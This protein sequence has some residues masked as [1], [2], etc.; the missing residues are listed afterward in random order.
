MGRKG[1]TKKV[2]T[3]GA[4]YQGGGVSLGDLLRARG[5]VP[6]APAPAVAGTGEGPGPTGTK[7]PPSEALSPTPRPT[8]REGFSFPAKVVVRRE[9][10]GRGG[11]TVTRVQ[12]LGWGD[13]ALTDLARTMARALGCGA[14]IEDG[15]VVLQGD[16]GDRAAGWLADQ[17]VRQ[18]VR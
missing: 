9:R 10:K 17:G 6:E 11:R 2:P 15:D 18:V 14:G 12:G 8:D 13:D 16:L 5:L 3:D 4:T 7:T 1:D